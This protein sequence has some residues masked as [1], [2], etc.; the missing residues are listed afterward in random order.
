MDL[1]F[2]YHFLICRYPLYVLFI[3]F[4]KPHC[5]MIVQLQFLIQQFTD[6]TV[7][8]QPERRIV[9]LDGAKQFFDIDLC[10]EFLP[11]LP[12]QCLFPGLVFFVLS[13]REFPKTRMF[14]MGSSGDHDL[15]IFLDDRSNDFQVL[16]FH[17]FVSYPVTILSYN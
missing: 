16:P 5:R 9:V 14:A 8:D 17:L 2:F 11:D 13:S 10:I 7:H 3:W 4:D 1:I 15:S 12:F 6:E